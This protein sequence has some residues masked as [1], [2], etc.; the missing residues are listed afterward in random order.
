[1]L[2]RSTGLDYS[3]IIPTYRRRDQLARCLAAVAAL[4]FAPD[5]FEVLVVDDGSPTPPADIVESLDGSLDLRLVC[6]PHGGPA[7]ARNAG[8]RLARGRYLVFTDDDCT[9]HR[10]WLHAIDQWTARTDAS[11]IIGGRVVNLLT[12]NLYAAASQGI[13]DYLYHYYGD[14]PSQQRFFT[15]NNLVV[16]RAEF[17]DIGGFDENFE[18]AAAEDRDLCERWLISG[19]EL[20][21]APDVIVD[22]AHTLSFSDFNQQHFHYGRGAFD[23]LRSRARR[24]E[25]S[26]RLEPVRFYSGLVAY[27]LRH[28]QTGRGVRLALLHFWSQVAYGAGYF[29]ERIRRGWKLRTNGTSGHLHARGR[30]ATRDDH[31]SADEGSMSGAA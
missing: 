31:A 23:L 26:F 16:P 11:R 30:G 29:F 4:D 22:H 20:Q 17:M 2:M 25:E 28:S 24:G 27:P 6:E 13:V 12:D 8:A 7:T 9:P 19:R 1:M 10:D 14:H 5:R 18:L 15:T 21:Y 3:I